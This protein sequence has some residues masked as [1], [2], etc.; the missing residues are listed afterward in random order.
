M[1]M[2]R[3]LRVKIGVPTARRMMLRLIYNKRQYSNRRPLKVYCICILFTDVM[4]RPFK[5]KT[6]CTYRLTYE[7]EVLQYNK[8]QYS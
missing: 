6:W 3:P 8:R 5:S 7:S 1:S 4:K 2:E